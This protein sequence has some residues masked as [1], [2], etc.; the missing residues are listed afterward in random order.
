MGNRRNAGNLSQYDD[1]DGCI[2][3]GL[4]LPRP[5]KKRLL[6]YPDLNYVITAGC[7]VQWKPMFAASHIGVSHETG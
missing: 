3:L 6:R 1:S 4:H 2:I 7:E 5:D